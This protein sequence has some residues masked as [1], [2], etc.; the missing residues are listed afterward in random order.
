MAITPTTTDYSGTSGV[1]Y[2]AVRK[3]AYTV[4]DLRAT[5]PTYTQ[6]EDEWG[7]LQAAYDG[8]Q[9][10]IAYGALLRHERESNDNYDRRKN[11][12]YG[13]S[14]STSVV[15]LFNFYLFKETVQRQ[16]GKLGDD[17]LW[18]KFTDDCNL[19]KDT[20]DDFLLEAGKSSSIQGCCGILVDKPNV[21]LANRR[22]EKEQNVYPYLSLYKPLA[23]LDW[24]YDRDEYNRPRLVFIKVRDDED[25][26]YRI[27]YPDKWEIW[28][29]PDVDEE[30]KTVIGTTIAKK[31]D[32]G[33]NPLGEIPWIWLY[34][35]KSTVRGYGR[36]DIGDISRID[37]SIMRNLSQGEEI[38]DYA[39]FP[40]MRKPWKEKGSTAKEDETGVT[41][42]LGF[43]PENPG[44]KPDWLDAAVSEPIGAIFDKVITK[45]I[46]E[47]YRSAN[48]GGMAATEIQKQ[49]KSGTALRS[50]FQLLNGKLVSKGKSLEKAE[51]EIIRF[52][53]MWQKDMALYDK[54]VVEWADTYEG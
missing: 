23:I 53:L 42:V 22:A 51:K 41:A 35:T 19:H 32:E 18:K 50:E 44:A 12:A 27:W 9:A 13:F 25:D 38:I 34:N 1:T 24:E 29:E 49:P 40:M 48:I 7:F 3:I 36:S 11:A 52:W 33:K 47:I 43:D 6:Y 26:L 46:E 10:L 20:L 16:L 4:D 14:Y 21:A 30:G 15:D 31:I 45:K 39:A 54:I 28:E 2:G 37:A 8:A 17:D 5:H